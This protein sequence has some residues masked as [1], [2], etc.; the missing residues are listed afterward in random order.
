[1]D[2]SATSSFSGVLMGMKRGG[3]CQSFRL[4]NIVNKVGV[5]VQYKLFSPLIKEIKIVKRA[6]RSPRRGGIRAFRRAQAYYIRER[7]ELLRNL[8][9]AIKDDAMRERAQAKAVASRK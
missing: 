1:M 3:V 9:G 8:A 5:E 6:E 4:R 7:P 2:K